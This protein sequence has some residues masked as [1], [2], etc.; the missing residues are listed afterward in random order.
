MADFARFVESLPT[1]PHKT[2]A[3][4]LLYIASPYSHEDPAVRQARFEAACRMTAELIRQGKPAYSPVVHSHPLCHYGLPLCW[5]FWQRHDL[6]FLEM[7]SEVV[8]LK[9]PQWE[10][11]VGVNAEIAAARAMGKPVTFMEPMES[12]LGNSVA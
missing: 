4:T 7:C 11:S 6:R 8:V 10:K 9:L 2:M 1:E 5:D 12:R 3:N